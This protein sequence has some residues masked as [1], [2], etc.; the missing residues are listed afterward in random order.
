MKLMLILGAGVLSGAL[1]W[2]LLRMSPEIPVSVT[3]NQS[4]MHASSPEA[5]VHSGD[6]DSEP[7]NA[8]L[9]T[10]VQQNA[11]AGA[12]SVTNQNQWPMP[13]LTRPLP[14]IPTIQIDGRDWSV[15]GTNDVINERGKNTV[16]VLR[17][18]V[19]GQLEYRQSSLRLVLKEGVDYESFIKVRPN[20]K[21]LFVNSLYGEIAVDAASIGAEY[22]TLSSDSRVVKVAFIPLVVPVKPK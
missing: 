5:S 16:L 18:E 14:K 3:A 17:D 15:L 2:Y 1:L 7:S 20:A 9:K 12:S 10:Q 4:S 19:S 21:R 22:T 13:D 8:P 11:P 6:S